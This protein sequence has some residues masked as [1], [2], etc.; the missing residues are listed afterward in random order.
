MTRDELNQLHV[1][2]LKI[3][4]EPDR[5]KFMDLVDELIVLLEHNQ[6][7]IDPNAFTRQR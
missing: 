1:L 7:V 4:D 5:E 2:C 3:Q 6:V